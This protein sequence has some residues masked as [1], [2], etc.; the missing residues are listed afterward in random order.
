MDE[1]RQPAAASG[2]KGLEE[3]ALTLFSH[4]G[5]RLKELPPAQRK[6]LAIAVAFSVVCVAAIVW[7]ATRTDW[8][9]L[10][11]GLDAGDAR[12]MAAELTAASIPYD[13][14]SDGT[15]LRVPAESL[16]KARLTTTA[17]GG[18]RSG[19]M[20]FDLFD[21]PNWVGSEFDEKV[22]Y[23]R[24]LEGE[25]E[26][27]I[28]TLADVESARV[29]LVLPHDSLFNEQQRDAKASVVLKLRHRT[30]SQ[31][32][33]EAV[34]NLVASA[35]DDLHPEH[36]VLVDAEGRQLGKSSGS[37]EI[38]AYEQQLAAKLVE[39]LEP[40]A[41]SGNVHASVNVEYDTSIADE[42]DETYDPNGVVT[43]SMQR[44]EQT[45]GAATP[46]G[47]PGTASN[48]PNVQPPLYPKTTPETQSEKQESGTYGASKRVRHTTQ[49]AG[50]LHRLTAAILIN[51]RKAINGKKVS[52]QPRSAEEMK[53]LAELAQATVGYDAAR[54]DIVNV[55]N[56][57]FDDQA[58]PSPPLVERLLQS[59]TASQ[60]LLK[61]GVVLLGMFGLLFFVVRP[62]MRNL[63]I[64]GKALPSPA[65]SALAAT[66]AMP[67]PDPALLAAEKQREEAQAIFESVTE[68]LRREP[69]QSTR[70]LQSWIHTE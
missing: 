56:L 17:K 54:G 70:L 19:R 13:V 36:V 34:R 8:R 31:D 20:G 59:A 48:A 9:T 49:G 58:A 28:G 35:V 69:A 1:N 57:Y 22:N 23:Q 7:Y 15:A 63:Q 14:S 41:G 50:K 33:A 37:A 3:R 10:Y 42:V 62:V 55:E 21:K 27:T 16:D 32:E 39:T 29:H 24:A 40:V 25:L 66:H 12:E 5:L 51:Y 30:L 46:A 67:A 43:L 52:W 26:H 4:L 45:A 18:P 47:V 6:W 65:D 44:S 2:N 68:R 53:H 64:A 60:P 61:L 11:A 38:A